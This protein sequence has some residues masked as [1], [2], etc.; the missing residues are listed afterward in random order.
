MLC[1]WI[2]AE[3]PCW[4]VVVVISQPLSLFQRAPSSQGRQA[5]KRLSSRLAANTADL[6]LRR[7]SFRGLH[8]CRSYSRT[9]PE[10]AT[11]TPTRPLLA[12]PRHSVFDAQPYSLGAHCFI[13]ALSLANPT[14]SIILHTGQPYLSNPTLPLTRH[15]EIR[16]SRMQTVLAL[17][18][19]VF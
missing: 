18:D 14:V 19:D 12:C 17:T 16:S 15:G 3:P 8:S 6:T 4:W 1:W 11:N 2:N 7:V 10:Q 5:Q 13:P 9:D